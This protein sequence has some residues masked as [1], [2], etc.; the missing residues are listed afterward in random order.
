MALSGSIIGPIGHLSAA[1]RAVERGD[2]STHVPLFGKD[3][4]TALS[5]AFN[6]MVE[7]L[8]ERRELHAAI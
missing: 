3:E 4:L 1:A 2:L 7:G 5:R 6:Q 8:A